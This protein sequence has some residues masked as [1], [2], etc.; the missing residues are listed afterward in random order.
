[1]I[2]PYGK[3]IVVA[4]EELEEVTQGGI[5]IPESVKEKEKPKKGSVLAVSDS[6]TDIKVGDKVIFGKYSGL[7]VDDVLILKIEDVHAVEKA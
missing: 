5:Y 6:I 7:E 4:R 1:M 2:L 3:R